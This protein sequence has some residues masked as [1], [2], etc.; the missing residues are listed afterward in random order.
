M[1]TNT[2]AV[3]NSVNIAANNNFHPIDSPVSCWLF[4]LGGGLQPPCGEPVP[5]ICKFI[6]GV[7]VVDASK[8]LI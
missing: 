3:I 5:Q 7:R 2:I 6:L 1:T 8:F 4:G